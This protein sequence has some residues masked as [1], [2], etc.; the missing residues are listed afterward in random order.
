M[1]KKLL[2]EIRSLAQRLPQTAE[3]VTAVEMRKW[4]ELTKEVQ[5]QIRER[6]NIPDGFDY[7]YDK[8]FAVQVEKLVSVDHYRR[9]KRAYTKGGFKRVQEY[10]Q[11]VQK[12]HLKLAAQHPELFQ[13][14]EQ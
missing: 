13:K 3:K 12:N 9:L 4:G 11:H 14:V 5:Q 8:L 7:S 6:D 10:I 2:K 1:K